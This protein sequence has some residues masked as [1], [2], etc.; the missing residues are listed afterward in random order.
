MFLTSA[1]I[2]P[3]SLWGRNSCLPVLGTRWPGNPR[4]ASET[5]TVRQWHMHKSAVKWPL[6]DLT[7]ESFVPRETVWVLE[8]ERIGDELPGVVS[9][10]TPMMLCT[11]LKKRA[12]FSTNPLLHLT[13][14]VR[15]KT[16]EK[17]VLQ[18]K[19]FVILVN[20][21]M[22]KRGSTLLISLDFW[23]RIFEKNLDSQQWLFNT[24]F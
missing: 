14:M 1:F 13:F 15:G 3:C 6:V 20:S 12:L 5:E 9:V 16:W 11:A 10:Q 2:S 22:L 17:N 18:W 7:K 8:T 23:I 21:C 4:L 24:Y 19:I